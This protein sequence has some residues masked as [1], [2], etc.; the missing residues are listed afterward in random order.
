[1]EKTADKWRTGLFGGTFSPPHLGHRYAAE[2]FLREVWRDEQIIKPAGIAPQN[3]TGPGDRPEVRYAMCKAMFRGLSRTV[4]SDYEIKKSGLSYTVETLEHLHEERA[5]RTIDLLCGT[6]MFL[7]LDTWHRA[8]DIFRLAEI[9]CMARDD[10]SYQEVE[11]KKQ[12]YE[13]RFGQRIILLPEA[14]HVISSTEVREKIRKKE[15][16]SA[17]LSQDVIE[18]IEKEGL[19]L[20]H[21]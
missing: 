15:D 21:E 13:A 7:S 3:Q 11:R 8:S 14:P 19:Y 16:L 12:E 4:V 20:S 6:D 17:Y 5:G 1:M 2:S 9:V 18:I 10:H